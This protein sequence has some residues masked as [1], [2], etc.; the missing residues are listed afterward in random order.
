MREVSERW[1]RVSRGVDKEGEDRD[2]R[3]EKGRER[4]EIGNIL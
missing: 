4:Y 2:R 3:V 1:E